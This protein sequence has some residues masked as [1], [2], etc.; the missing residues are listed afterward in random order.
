MTAL[1]GIWHGPTGLKKMAERIRFYTQ[2]LSTALAGMGIK[3]VT[4]KHDFFDTIVIDIKASGFTSADKVLADF[5]KY[6]INLRK[7]DDFHVGISLNETTVILKLATV[8]EIFALL[9]EKK[10]L[11]ETYLPDDFFTI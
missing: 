9:L 10:E 1:Y 6:G 3:V 7:V 11:G 8:V 5:H 4:H 2:M